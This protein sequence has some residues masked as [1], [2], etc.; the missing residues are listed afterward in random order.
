MARQ[1][2]ASGKTSRKPA[3]WFEVMDTTL[4]DGEQTE[5]VSISANEKLTI[6]RAL[7]ETLKVD[8]IEVASARV[9]EGEHLGKAYLALK[10]SAEDD[11]AGGEKSPGDL[12]SGVLLLGD[13]FLHIP[14]AP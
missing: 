5:G 3:K 9:S 14:R 4:R 7:L 12:V 13:P 11:D 2:R 6:A 1:N 8:Y 10:Q